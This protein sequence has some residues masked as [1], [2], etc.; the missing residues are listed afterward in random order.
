[1]ASSIDMKR[2]PFRPGRFFLILSGALVVIVAVFNYVSSRAT[3]H[4]TFTSHFETPLSDVENLKA[5]G[6]S[7][8]VVSEQ[9]YW[10][11]FQSGKEVKLQSSA[12]PPYRQIS[13]VEASSIPRFGTGCEEFLQKYS[14]ANVFY[15]DF[16]P[17]LPGGGNMLVHDVESGNYCFADWF[18]SDWSYS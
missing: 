12:E 14:D 1:M 17:G 4:E 13:V 9:D 15:R 3:I 11:T 16:S 6:S 18:H 7:G 10:L 5:H 2:R 8:G